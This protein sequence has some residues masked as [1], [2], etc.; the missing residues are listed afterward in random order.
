[1]PSL[2]LLV[3][4]V[5]LHHNAMVVSFDADFEAIATVSKFR[6]NRLKRPALVI[7]EAAERR[8]GKRSA[9]AEQPHGYSGAFK[10]FYEKEK[11]PAEN[12]SLSLSARA[13]RQRDPQNCFYDLIHKFG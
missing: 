10:G 1:M 5:A 4:A 13:H 7:G 6:L 2:D 3:A 8:R 9:T 12:P 11:S